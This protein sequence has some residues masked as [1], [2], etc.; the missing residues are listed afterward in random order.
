MP[1]NTH[2]F[3][4]SCKVTYQNVTG[5]YVLVNE[6]KTRL[7]LNSDT[8]FK[9]L[10][11]NKDPYLYTHDH[12]DQR[13]YFTTG[14][15]Y[16]NGRKLQLTSISD[17]IIYNAT[18]VKLTKSKEDYSE[19]EF[20]DIY[21]DSVGAGYIILPD[22]STVIPGFDNKKNFYR[23]S[24]DITKIKSLEFVFYGYGHWKYSA[25]D[26]SNYTINVQFIP[27]FKPNIFNKTLFKV[28]GNTI[29]QKIYM[30]R[31]KFQKIKS[32]IFT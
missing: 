28:R 9:F 19:F 3:F 24:E 5:T 20:Y 30:K 29:I 15:F 17:S 11:I 6:P 23:F 25:D 12:I 32:T 18:N 27:V 2:D 31:F 4:S 7:I 21:N 16:L 8:T 14:N 1:I 22:S 26:N 13:F 10:K